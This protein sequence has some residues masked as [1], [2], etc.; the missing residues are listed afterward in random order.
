MTSPLLFE[1]K[2]HVYMCKGSRNQPSTTQVNNASRFRVVCKKLTE[3]FGDS[4]EMRIPVTV[5]DLSVILIHS[6]LVILSHCGIVGA[7]GM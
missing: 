2:R 1:C 6:L 4:V 3:A 7:I 5:V